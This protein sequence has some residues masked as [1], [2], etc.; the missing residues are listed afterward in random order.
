MT[1]L[2]R[3]SVS[4]S[5]EWGQSTLWCCKEC[6]Q[7]SACSVCIWQVFTSLY[8]LL[9]T[10]MEAGV[11]GKLRPAHCIGDA[12]GGLPGQVLLLYGRGVH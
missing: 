8:L 3:A 1:F 6:T 12:A 10:G 2:F 11:D 7:V 4:S 9:P 5:G